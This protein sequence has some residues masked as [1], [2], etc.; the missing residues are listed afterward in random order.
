MAENDKPVVPDITGGGAGGKSAP[1]IKT[2]PAHGGKRLSQK[3]KAIVLLGGGSLVALTVIGIMQASHHAN[4]GSSAGSA[5]PQIGISQPPSPPPPMTLNQNG[6]AADNLQQNSTTA[7]TVSSHAVALGQAG[8]HKK[9][10]SAEKYQEWLVN[11]HYKMLEAQIQDQTTAKRSKLSAGNGTGIMSS[12]SPGTAV[13]NFSVD[14]NSY[15]QAALKAISQTGTVPPDLLKKI[16][17]MEGT[18][19]NGQGESG[20]NANQQFLTRQKGAKDKNGYLDES[21][22]K[23][24]SHN[25]VTAG[26]IIPAVMVTGINSDLPGEIVAQV[27]Q[28]VYDSL[29]PDRVLIPQGTKIIGE[30]SSAVAYGQSRV[31]VAWNRLIYPN[32]ETIALQGMP[33]TNGIG[34]AGF[35]DLVDNHY[36]RIFGSAILIS[37]IGA[38]AQLSQPQQSSAFQNPTPGQ[39]AAAAMAQEM[40]SV[41]TN[42]LNKNLNIQPTLKIRPGYL[43]NVLVT[44]TMILPPYPAEHP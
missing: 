24:L 2:A 38:G 4:S 42:L 15:L 26:S 6:G 31:L 21:L 44:R 22:Q 5:P 33:G 18:G 8:L 25:E 41:G 39:T 14:P 11:Y 13:G 23:P 40:D 30:Y 37:L 32:G 7:S 43:F 16:Q 19:D 12:A 29:D 17:G 9:L 3:G 28:T 35:H 1:I 10:T 34:E 27:R 20:Q 36:W